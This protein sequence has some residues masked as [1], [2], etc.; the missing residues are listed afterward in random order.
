[1]V[2][3]TQK[4]ST[5]H[6]SVWSMEIV[7]VWCCAPCITANMQNKSHIKNIVESN[8][9]P[10]TV[11]TSPQFAFQKW[12]SKRFQSGAAL[13]MEWHYDWGRAAKVTASMLFAIWCE[14][15]TILKQ[16]IL[17]HKCQI[18]WLTFF[19]SQLN[20]TFSKQTTK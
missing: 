9:R 16:N 20:G 7:T 18:D 19:S 10:N 14:L 15:N 12:L 1:M 11:C 2:C 4:R 8:F 3:G 6:Y 5:I 13:S 17:L